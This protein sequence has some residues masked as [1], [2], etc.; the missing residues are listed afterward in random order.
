MRP[1]FDEL[2]KINLI[3]FLAQIGSHPVR[4]Y[5]HYAL[6]HAP[7]R[8][9]EHPSFNVYKAKNRWYD[10]A[11][12]EGGDIIDLGYRIYNTTDIIE[13]V[14][15]ISVFDPHIAE[16][17]YTKSSQQ[18]A[19][20]YSAK[21]FTLTALTNPKLLSYLTDRGID[22]QYAQRY[23][24]EVHYS[25]GVKHYYAVGFMN[26]SDG[27]EVRN[28]FFKGC[29][30]SKDITHI[31]LHPDN[32]V[33]YVFEGFIDFL[34]FLTLNKRNEQEHIN[35]TSDFLI[36]N[37]VSNIHKAIP[38][39]MP[40]KKVECYLDNDDAG[41]KAT[42]TLTNLHDDILDASGKYGNYKDV[43]DLLNNKPIRK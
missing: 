9:D 40:Y 34:S 16:M 28:N 14:K 26:I 42:A 31:Q 18:S 35:E 36:L 22:L 41:R 7:Y 38:Y 27:F 4:N 8:K 29:F 10:L 30:G 1:N 21:D 2:K 17:Q 23:C 3:E 33:C 6:F 32:K 19:D 37:S 13:V 15:R 25:I 11:L 12:C 39:V 5:A 43:N 20:H 24:V